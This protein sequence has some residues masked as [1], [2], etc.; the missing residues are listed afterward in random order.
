MTYR[1]LFLGGENMQV[2]KEEVYQAIQEVAQDMFLYNGYESTSLNAIAKKV[3]ISKS[4][5][6]SYKF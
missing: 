4:N 2:L 6:Y 1:L 3:G 5:M